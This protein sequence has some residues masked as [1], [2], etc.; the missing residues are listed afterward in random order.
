MKQKLLKSAIC[1]RVPLMFSPG[2]L[3][4]Y[5]G[6]KRLFSNALPRNQ[7]KPRLIKAALSQINSLDIFLFFVSESA[8]FGINAFKSVK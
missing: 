7:S 6:I 3:L 5:V 8:N 2:V 1:E 4:L